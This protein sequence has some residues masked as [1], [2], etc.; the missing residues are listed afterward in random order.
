M[1]IDELLRVP[2]QHKSIL[3]VGI[4]LAQESDP[5]HQVDRD[6]NAALDESVQELILKHPGSTDGVGRFRASNPQ[7][8]LASDFYLGG[9]PRFPPA[10]SISKAP[11]PEGGLPQMQIRTLSSSREA[12]ILYE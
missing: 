10:L 8:S 9:P 6:G 3:V 1:L 11:C 5:I 7:R 12:P 2:A 4:D